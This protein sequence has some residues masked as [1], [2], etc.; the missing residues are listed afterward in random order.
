MNFK[1]HRPLRPFIGLAIFTIVAGLT[2]FMS[3][4]QRGQMA[5]PQSSMHVPILTSGPQEEELPG[6]PDDWSFHHLNFTDPGTEEEA[7]NA[8]RH[9]EWLRIVNEP[10]YI[11]QQLKRRQP[12][13]GPWADYVAKMNERGRTLEDSGEAEP[14]ADRVEQLEASFRPVKGHRPARPVKEGIDRDWSMDLGASAAARAGQYPAKYTFS[15][16]SANC[17]DYV[18][19]P[20]GATGSSSQATIV[21]YSNLYGTSGPNGTGCGAGASGGAVPEV[22]WAYNTPVGSTAAT[23]NLSPV[24][25]FNG[26]QVAFVETAGSTAYLVLLHMAN[27]GGSATSPATITSSSSYPCT[28]PCYTTFT[29]GAADTNSP[30]FYD[31]NHDAIYVG[32]ASGK[33][34]KFSPVFRGTAAE[35]TGAN[36]WPETVRSG[37]QLTGPVLDYN[38]GYIFVADHSGY[39]NQWSSS[40]G[41][42]AVGASNSMSTQ[43]IPDAPVVDSGTNSSTNPSWVYVENAY[44]GST[45]NPAYLNIFNGS[46]AISGYGTSVALT[47]T[48]STSLTIYA[49][50]F[51]NLHT[52]TTTG[53]YYVCATD[54]TSGS[55][56]TTL[57]QVALGGTATAVTLT[58]YAYNQVSS[59]NTSPTCSPVAEFYNNSTDYVYLSVTANGDATASCTGAC[60]YNYKVPTSTGTHTGSATAGMTV[61]SGASGVIIDN[62]LT[63]PAGA[64]QIYFSSLASESCAG[65]GTTGSGTGGCAVQASQSSP[66]NPVT[67]NGT[68]TFIRDSYYWPGHEGCTGTCSPTASVTVGATTYTFVATINGT[69]TQVQTYDSGT[70]SQDESDAAQNLAAALLNDSTKCSTDTPKPCFYVSG[71]NASVTATYSSNVTSLTAKTSGSGGDFALSVSS[72]AT[73]DITVSGGNNGSP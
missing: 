11:I 25:D 58:K 66:S 61:A 9:E 26:T 48:G 69:S 43:G 38:S 23:A 28:A 30:P 21:A 67:A 68:V 59:T 50:A 1:N 40:G 60:L 73:T 10:R 37:S 8:D 27:S 41:T 35:V 56:N 49:G 70:T 20:T 14:S 24:I 13:Q 36:T 19:Y 3:G 7:I 62:S 53:N 39:L 54:V 17:S 2:V 16:T 4:Q 22:Y 46:S 47:T 29:L 65:N 44:G 55:A 52:S 18:V 57:Y 15:T 5:N 31:Y 32:D 33:M 72:D 71:A 6:L 63:S 42:T 64:S 34:H 45:G 51:D 12:A